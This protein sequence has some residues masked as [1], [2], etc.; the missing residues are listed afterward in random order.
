VGHNA[1]DTSY[2]GGGVSRIVAEVSGVGV[3]GLGATSTSNL[4][5]VLQF[6]V[7]KILVGFGL[8]ETLPIFFGTS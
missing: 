3:D 6:R 8:P 5:F 7:L 4:D 2:V 1:G